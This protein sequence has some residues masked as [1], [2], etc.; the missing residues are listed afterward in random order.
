MQKVILSLPTPEKPPDRSRSRLRT[1]LKMLALQ[2]ILGTPVTP[3]KAHVVKVEDGF[4]QVKIRI[5]PVSAPSRTHT[6]TDDSGGSFF[7]LPESALVNAIGPTACL[8]GKKI[9]A[10]CGQVYDTRV[11]ILLAN[12]IDRGVLEHDAGGQGYRWTERYRRARSRMV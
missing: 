8:V 9:A 10:I 5:A 4:L 1:Y 7:S 6:E 2:A 11:K 3:D 12:L